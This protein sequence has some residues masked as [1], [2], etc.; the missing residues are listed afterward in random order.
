VLAGAKGVHTGDKWADTFCNIN[1]IEIGGPVAECVTHRR[2]MNIYIYSK[3][4][5]CVLL[6]SIIKNLLVGG[7]EGKAKYIYYK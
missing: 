6:F 2:R 5:F 1:R 7:G 4:V 3:V